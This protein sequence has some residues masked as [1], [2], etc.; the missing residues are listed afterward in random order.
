MKLLTSIRKLLTAPSDEAELQQAW[1]AATKRAEEEWLA[2]RAAEAAAAAKR[3]ANIAK[4]GALRI[5][6]DGQKEPRFYIEEFV[7]E[8]ERNTRP[9]FLRETFKWKRLS[10]SPI[11]FDEALV[12]FKTRRHAEEIVGIIMAREIEM[13]EVQQWTSAQ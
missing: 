1:Q 8:Y 9:P 12:G 13:V 3:E 4:V 5:T 7:C 11:P 10:N 6:M 2:E